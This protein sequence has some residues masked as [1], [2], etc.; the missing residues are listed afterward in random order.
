MSDYLEFVHR[1]AL[2][3]LMND[4]L[5]MDTDLNTGEIVIVYYDVPRRFPISLLK[6]AYKKWCVEYTVTY[7]MNRL[8]G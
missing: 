3:L 4:G 5:T 2:N 1:V 7:I 6:E 8:K